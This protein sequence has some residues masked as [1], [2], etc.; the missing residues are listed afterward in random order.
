MN[1]AEKLSKIVDDL[2]NPRFKDE[3][4]AIRLMDEILEIHVQVKKNMPIRRKLRRRI[5]RLW[6][7]GLPLDLYQQLGLHGLEAKHIRVICGA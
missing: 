6:A 7:Y 2:D 5:Q 1:V 3:R 4:Q